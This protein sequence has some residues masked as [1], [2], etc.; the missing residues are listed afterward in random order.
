[1]RL[2]IWRW[3]SPLISESS[4]GPSTPQFHDR[5]FEVP[6]RLSSPLASLR[7]SLYDTRS[8]SVKPSCAVTK[9]T[10]AHGRRPLL[11][12]RSADPARRDASSGTLASSPRQ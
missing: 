3:R 10:L 12:N 9:L 5:L 11:L 2:R 8:F 7:L 4:V 1:M 6:S